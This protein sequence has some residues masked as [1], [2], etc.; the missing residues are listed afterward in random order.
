MTSMDWTGRSMSGTSSQDLEALLFWRTMRCVWCMHENMS[1]EWI[2]S[3]RIAREKLLK[4]PKGKRKWTFLVSFKRLGTVLWEYAWIPKAEISTARKWYSMVKITSIKKR[5]MSHILWKKWCDMAAI[6]STFSGLNRMGF[7]ADP[8]NFQFVLYGSESESSF[9][10]FWFL[11]EL[12][13]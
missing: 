13:Y 12:F 7:F 5:H 9:S 11:D 8:R 2:F 4:I 3:H 6:G 10:S 1:L